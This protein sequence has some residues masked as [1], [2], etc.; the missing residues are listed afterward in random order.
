MANTIGVQKNPFNIFPSGHNQDNT[1]AVLM[2]NSDALDGSCYGTNDSN[3]VIFDTGYIEPNTFIGTHQ[4]LLKWFTDLPSGVNGLTFQYWRMD[5]SSNETLI[6]SYDV[7]YQPNWSDTVG[8]G[9]LLCSFSENYSYRFVVSSL[10]SLPSGNFVAVDYLMIKSLDDW[11]ILSYK[12]QPGFGD[13][14]GA[15]TIETRITDT[16]NITGNSTPYGQATYTLPTLGPHQEIAVQISMYT[17]AP[18]GG[19]FY[20][21]EWGNVVFDSNGENPSSFV[22]TVCCTNGNWSGTISVTLEVTTY[23]TVTPV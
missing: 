16:L 23:V 9:L 7:P 17:D 11:N 1:K 6:N 12:I 19:G 13:Q 18:K 22:V 14:T 20:T 2:Q 4:V 21:L 10:S 3:Q 5:S 8:D 15:S